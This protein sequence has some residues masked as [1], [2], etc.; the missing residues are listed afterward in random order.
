M[1]C[2]P[3]AFGV[4]KVMGVGARPERECYIRLSGIRGFTEGA[5]K[6]RVYTSD[7]MIYFV[8]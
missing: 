3:C 1:T 8:L 5:G 6:Y 4:S 2:H 7:E